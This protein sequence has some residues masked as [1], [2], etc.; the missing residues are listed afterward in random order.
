MNSHEK[1][2]REARERSERCR[3]WL[4]TLMTPGHPKPATKDE[5]FEWARENLGANRSN[6]NAGWD[7]AIFD[8]GREDWYLP[9]PRR[10]GDEN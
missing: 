6:F 1:A 10:R 8:T 9:L 7:L 4:K 2:A 5:L 3:E